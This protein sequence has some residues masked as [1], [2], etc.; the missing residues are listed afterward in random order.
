MRGSGRSRVEPARRSVSERP[1]DSILWVGRSV[2]TLPMQPPSLEEREVRPVPVPKEVERRLNGLTRLV[3]NTPL[4]AIDLSYRGERRV[5]Y[6]KAE[7]LNMTGSIKDRMALHILYR[8]Y[9]RGLLRPGDLIVEATSGNTG[10]AFSGIGRALGHPVAI[11]MPDWMS[12][13]RINLIRSFGARIELV[14]REQGGLRRQHRPRRGA[15]GRNRARVPA[16]PVLERGQ[17][18]GALL[19]YG[20]RDVAAVLVALADTG[21][22]RRWGRYRR[23]DHGSGVVPP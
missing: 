23:D 11:Y 6:A 17:R 5:L 18:R 13:E 2:R 8:A 20:T 1:P 4:L 7:H 19:D 16:A 15:R 10:L 12:R 9:Q 21:C 22:L 3:G 14:S